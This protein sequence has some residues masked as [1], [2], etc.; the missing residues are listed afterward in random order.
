MGKIKI[1]L[2]SDIVCPWCIIGQHRLDKVLKERFAGMAFNIEHHPY[3]LQPSAPP[4]GLNLV[5]YFRSKGITDM[6]VAFARP[7]A[8]ARASGLRLDLGAQQYVYRTIYA[9]TLL[10]AAKER[11]TQHTLAGALM[12]AFFHDQRNI[13]DVDTLSEIASDYGFRREDVARL[14]A[15]ETELK[16][17]DAEIA[18]ARNAG[19]SSVPTFKING[20]T[21]IGGRSE[22]EIAAWIDA[23]VRAHDAAQ[24]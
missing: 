22:D 18:N 5:N 7:E 13:S 6:R 24:Q 19:V 17:T 14:L 21:L 11:G 8:E 2:Y 10:R 20:A 9:H 23:A 1:D 12:R 15:D 3:E 4:G 16:R